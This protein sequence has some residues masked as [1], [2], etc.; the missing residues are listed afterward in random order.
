M[1]HSASSTRSPS[2]LSFTCSTPCVDGC[3]GPMLIVISLASNKVSLVDIFPSVLWR[4]VVAFF[5]S[6][7]VD[8]VLL[9]RLNTEVLADPLHI[10]QPEVVVLAQRKSLPVF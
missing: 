7:R 4:H 2:S 1:T 6:G 10:L 9:T 8:I 5:C 3:C